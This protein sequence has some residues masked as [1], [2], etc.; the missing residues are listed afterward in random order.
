M[1]KDHLRAQRLILD[2]GRGPAPKKA[3]VV[4]GGGLAKLV[5]ASSVEVGRD[6]EALCI[7]QPFV[8]VGKLRKLPLAI[9]DEDE[10]PQRL[11][12]LAC[13]LPGLAASDAC[14]DV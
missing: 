2:T 6:I 14:D 5:A 3:A 4:P 13:A 9:F 8:A 11:F 12:G 10:P 1:V 7:G